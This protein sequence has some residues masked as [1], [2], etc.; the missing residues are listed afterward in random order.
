MNFRQI[1][2]DLVRTARIDHVQAAIRAE[3]GKGATRWIA[4]RAGISQRTAR[5]WMSSAPP[6]TRAGAIVALIAGEAIAA[7]R[8]RTA[9]H[10]SVGA[11]AVEYDG[12]DE[13]TRV[14]GELDVTGFMDNELDNCAAA[15]E[16][17]DWDAA[18]DAFSD[19]VIAGYSEG[20]QDTLS[21]FDYQDGVSLSE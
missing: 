2:N 5:R 10:I 15:L 16:E 7:A 9:T 11:V 13:G 8:I 17:G 12:A 21:V 20:L 1:V 3:H 18:A 6:P 4:E 19:A 14:I